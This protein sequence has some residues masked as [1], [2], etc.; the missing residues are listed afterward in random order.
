MKSN[1][2]SGGVIALVSLMAF[3]VPAGAA[4]Q[5]QMIGGWIQRRGSAVK[6]PASPN[7]GI[8]ANAIVSQTGVAPRTLT[9]PTGAFKLTAVTGGTKVVPVP[10]PS[11]AQLA[12]NFQADGPAAQTLPG[13]NVGNVLKKSGWVG[14]RVNKTFAWCPGAS[15]NPGCLNR[16]SSTG[17]GGGAPPGSGLQHGIVRYTPVGAN[18][19]GGTMQMVL[20]TPLGPGAVGR[21]FGPTQVAHFA[22]S[23]MGNQILGGKYAQTN[24]NTLPAAPI[25]VPVSRTSPMG[26]IL[27]GGPQVG[28]FGTPTTNKNYGFSWTTGKVTASGSNGGGAAET[29][30]IL[31]G[32][33]NRAGIG[34]GTLSLVSGGISR[35]LGTG[36][37]FIN[38][39][40]ITMTMSPPGTIPAMTPTVAATAALLMLGVGFALRKRLF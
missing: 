35:R 28:T 12:T 18:A 14:N 20:A 27:V 38:L 37:T 17:V 2:I 10:V 21:N 7:N 4:D 24:Q 34:S 5:F 15:K 1:R 19:F 39:D 22:V 26:I 40:S 8:P 30:W 16:D 6:I 13:L 25:T 33:D 3:A 32:A 29:I 31:Q 9:I 36:F 23:G 11:L